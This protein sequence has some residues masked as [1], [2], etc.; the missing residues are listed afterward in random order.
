M[1]QIGFLSGSFLSVMGLAAA[2]FMIA[3]AATAANLPRR[4]GQCVE[5]RVKEVATRLENTPGSGSAI[6][7]ENGGYGVSYEQVPAVDNS[8]AGDPVTL[9]LVSIPKGCPPGDNR[10][11]RYRAT[12]KRTGQSW[13]LPD[14]EHMCGGA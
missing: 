14:A 5:T 3:D 10:G 1:M 7:F 11:R 12:N 4:V 6:D 2:T 9:C 8:R 13:T